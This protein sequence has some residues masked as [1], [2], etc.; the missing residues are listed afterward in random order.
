[1]V[2][3]NARRRNYFKRVTGNSAP[4]VV[5]V[6]ISNL[7]TR[8]IYSPYNTF[9]IRLFIHNNWYVGGKR[10]EHVRNHFT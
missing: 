9:E 3:E 4:R 5:M 6:D 8:I 2:E 10:P 7:V 1:M